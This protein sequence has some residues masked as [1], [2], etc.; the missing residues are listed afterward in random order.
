ME[1]IELAVAARVL[2]A[3]LRETR[4]LAALVGARLIRRADVTLIRRDALVRIYASLHQ[5]GEAPYAA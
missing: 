4:D 2:G 5:S 1:H 3:S